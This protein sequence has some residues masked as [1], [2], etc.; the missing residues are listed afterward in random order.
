MSPQFVITT[1]TT[2]GTWDS[3]Y[4]G[5]PAGSGCKGQSFPRCKLVVVYSPEWNVH[6]V[7]QHPP[8]ITPSY[9]PRC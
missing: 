4:L 9:G 5:W 8:I 1:P 7:A 3:E 6:Q 2:V